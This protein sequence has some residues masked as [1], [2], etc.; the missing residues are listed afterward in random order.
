MEPFSSQLARN[1]I[2]PHIKLGLIIKKARDGNH[3]LWLQATQPKHFVIIVETNPRWLPKTNA[4]WKKIPAMNMIKIHHY[5]INKCCWSLWWWCTNWFVNNDCYNISSKSI[6][7][8]VKQ[9][10][11]W[12]ASARFVPWGSPQ[13]EEVSSSM[14]P[15]PIT[16]FNFDRMTFYGQSQ[17]CFRPCTPSSNCPSIHLPVTENWW[18]FIHNLVSC[19]PAI[20][21]Y[22]Q[23]IYIYNFAWKSSSSSQQITWHC[24]SARLFAMMMMTQYSEHSQYPQASM[25]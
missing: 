21:I 9:E 2:L 18:G 8:K 19:N 5:F 25:S 3:S 20:S 17:K 1:H 22:Y 13:M 15:P 4:I 6:I 14:K 11:V 10:R 12:Q 7:Y 16:R 23:C 24:L